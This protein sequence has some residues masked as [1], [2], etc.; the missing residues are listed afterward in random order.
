[1][2]QYSSVAVG[3]EN[4]LRSPVW[5]FAV[6]AKSGELSVAGTLQSMDAADPWLTPAAHAPHQQLPTPKISSPA[7]FSFDLFIV[8]SSC[9]LSVDIFS[10]E[11]RYGSFNDDAAR[12]GGSAIT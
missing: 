10:P 3:P 8:S 7:T 9:S 6:L 4:F 12:C 11:S 2:T 1:M 5:R